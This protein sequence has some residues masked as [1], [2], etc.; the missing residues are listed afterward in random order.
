MKLPVV[1]YKLC[2]IFKPKLVTP[3][4]LKILVEWQQ[5][6]LAI[7]AISDHMAAAAVFS[8]YSQE[9]DKLDHGVGRMLKFFPV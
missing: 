9:S 3:Q 8:S 4:S 7:E 6:L 5:N 1:H 2:S